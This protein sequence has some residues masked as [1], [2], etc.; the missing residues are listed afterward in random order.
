M[1]W[2]SSLMLEAHTYLLQLCIY[3]SV[4]CDVPATRSC[5][6]ACSCFRC[7]KRELASVCCA[8]VVCMYYVL[9][10]YIV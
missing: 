8:F 6:R 3:L 2:S 7:D 5:F 9:R 1:L 10:V 4:W